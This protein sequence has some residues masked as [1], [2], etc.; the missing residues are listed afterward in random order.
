MNLA[1][2]GQYRDVGLLL[3]R[4]GLGFFFIVV[5]GWPKISGGVERW[6][7]L[8]GAMRHLGIS[9]AP[10]M[11]GFLAAAVEFGGGILLVIGFL[12]RGTCFAL[13]VTMAVAATMVYKTQGSLFAAAH[14]IELG[15]VFLGLIFVGAGRFSL[16]RS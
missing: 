13:A 7:D 9:F 5:H 10:E 2:L 3:M 11:W 14:P 12:F 1:W 15:V 6:R 16:D 4:V 8:G